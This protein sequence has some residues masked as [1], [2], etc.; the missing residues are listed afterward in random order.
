M[1]ILETFRRKT[2]KI[3]LKIK[4]QTP[5][6]YLDELLNV[7]SLNYRLD[8]ARI[9]LWNQYS[10]APKYLLKHHTFNKW[11]RYILTNGGNVNESK[12]LKNR[13]IGRD[14]TFK[15]DENKFNFI[16]KSPLSQAYRTMDKILP[17]E[18]KIFRK[19]KSDVLK[20][21][22]CF[23]NIY[24]MNVNIYGIDR[25]FDNPRLISKSEIDPVLWEFYSDGSCM[26]NPGP[27]GSGYYSHD[28]T[29][30][31]RIEPIDHDT[32]INYCTRT[33]VQ[34]KPLKSAKQCPGYNRG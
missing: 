14:E 18:Q 31:S 2:A 30:N 19:R 26:P 28:F 32:T 22:P 20:P 23:N 24:P 33:H 13:Q 3:A 25:Q 16:I 11:R 5:T 17:I 29:I 4:K 1:N 7:K 21:V 6:I 8:V 34:V 9:K 27:G 10:R 12:H 15:L